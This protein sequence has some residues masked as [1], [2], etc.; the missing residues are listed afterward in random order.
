MALAVPME[1]PYGPMIMCSKQLEE[2]T[3]TTSLQKDEKE[4]MN[5]EERLRQ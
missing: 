5:E 3:H 4:N 2:H 1:T